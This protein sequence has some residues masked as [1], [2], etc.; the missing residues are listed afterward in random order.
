MV[1]HPRYSNTVYNF[2]D[3]KDKDFE[4]N[5]ENYGKF[6]FSICSPLTKPCNGIF[7]SAACF[8]IN[9]I[10]TNIGLFT[11]EIVFDNGKIY[12]SMHGEKCEDDG[13][14][15]YTVIRFVCDYSNT[16]IIKMMK[17]SIKY[18]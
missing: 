17:V 8:S 13:P 12:M 11:E 2:N 18:L 16:K 14:N 7:E 3:L 1:T 15:S 5:D 9:G 10:E 6:R 4:V